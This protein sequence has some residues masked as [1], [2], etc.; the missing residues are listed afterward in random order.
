MTESP[1]TIL[2]RAQPQQRT[3]HRVEDEKHEKQNT[4][5]INGVDVPLHAAGV[6][7]GADL[8]G[9]GIRAYDPGY[10]HTLSCTSSITAIDGAAGVLSHRGYRL[11]ALVANA[12][13]TEVAHLLVRGALPS[14]LQH[15]AWTRALYKKAIAPIGARKTLRALPRSA[16]PMGALV[17]TLA[18]TGATTDDMNPSRCRDTYN[19]TEGREAA[20]L[21]VLRCVPALAAAVMRHSR[22]ARTQFLRLP[23]SASQWSFARRFLYLVEPRLLSG[24]AADARV[25]AVDALLMVHADHEQNCSTAAL[26]HLASSGV[27]VFSAMAGAT[28]ALYG[29]LHGGASEAVVRMLRRV[30]GLQ[31]V[32][33]FLAAVKSGR[34]RLMGFGHRVYKNYDPRARIIRSLVK[35]AVRGAEGNAEL[36]AVAE[37]I[38]ESAL[39]DEYFVKR[40][41]F[42]NV[43]FYSGLVYL[44]MGFQPESFPVM[45]ALGRSAGWVAH[46]L[47]FMDDP[48]KRIIRP[49]QIYVG[50]NMQHRQVLPLPERPDGELLPWMAV[51]RAKM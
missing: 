28:A 11:E 38:E 35:E 10:A 3:S 19:T 14:T 49:H 12:S 47:E 5:R 16:H 20:A 45:F 8:A 22:G 46:W 23:S 44:S 36:L 2:V 15:N 18:A 24:A 40:R 51:R 32:D 6:V 33:T 48:H 7:R 9:A 13:Y 37:K 4:V 27:D 42:P 50:D 17:A 34:E 29:P 25:A 26:R 31:G 1:S 43:D 21:A 39:A 30:G 41:L